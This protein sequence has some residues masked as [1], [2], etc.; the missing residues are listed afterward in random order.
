VITLGHTKSGKI[1]QMISITGDFYLVILREWELC[2]VII[3]TSGFHCI[4]G[5]NCSYQGKMFHSFK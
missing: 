3:Y 4:F 2:Y 5:L 1:Y